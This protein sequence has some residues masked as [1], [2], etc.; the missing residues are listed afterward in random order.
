MRRVYV[1]MVGDLFHPGHVALLRAARGFGDTLIVGVL[2]DATV[3]E[4][5][6]VPVMTLEERVAVIRACRYVDNVIPDAPA[7]VTS[8]FMQRHEISL[9]VHGSDI[10]DEAIDEVYGD[11]KREGKL[12][13]VDPLP[14][15]STTA[16][17]ERVLSGAHAKKGS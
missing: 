12:E 5:K 7:V 4:Y 17:I 1:D 16:I 10:S 8:E 11:A 15:L 3:A 9:V 2:S 14:G 6:R 13:L